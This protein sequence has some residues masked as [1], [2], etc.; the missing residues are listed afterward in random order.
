[1]ETVTIEDLAGSF[2]NF[3]SA[4]AAVV[5]KSATATKKIAGEVLENRKEL[6]GFQ[7]QLDRIETEIGQ[8]KL[9]SGVRGT[10]DDADL[11]KYHAGIRSFAGGDENA[12]KNTMSVVG[13][14]DGGYLVQPSISKSFTGKMYDESPMRQ[15]CRNETITVGDAWVE[16]IDWDEP[17]S[18]FV[19][20][21]QARPAT[22]TPQVRM[23]TIPVNEQYALQTVTQRLIDDAGIDVGAWLEGKVAG[24]LGRAESAAVVSNNGTV[25][26]KGFLT[27]DVASTADATR[28]FGTLQ[29]LPSGNTTAIAADALKDTYWGL[30]APYRKDAVW[31]MNSNTANA[32]DKLKDGSGNYYF[33]PSMSAGAPPTLLGNPIVFE[34]N[35]PAV[36]AGTLPIAFGNFKRAY[37]I[38]DKLGVRFLRDPFTDKPNVIIYAYFRCGGGLVDSDA[39]KLMRIGTS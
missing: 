1:M 15:I 6:K 2:E 5:D 20:E 25:S 10:G 19:G 27:Y 39:I 11:K 17:G 12:L 30:R 8:A 29:Y 7:E 37:I 4:V 16:P 13:D 26:A 34:E 28:P 21:K 38:V 9:F 3:Q 31:T 32:I 23:V 22:T 14:P 36:G 35:M 33:R 24:K 18:A